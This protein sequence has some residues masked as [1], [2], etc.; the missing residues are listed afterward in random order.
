MPYYTT[1]DDCLAIARAEE[2]PRSRALV[3]AVRQRERELLARLTA[4]PQRSDN[5]LEDVG[6][7]ACELHGVQF[8]LDLIKAAKEQVGLSGGQ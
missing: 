8:V 7:I 1:S 2:D 4:A 3:M 5:L 6:G